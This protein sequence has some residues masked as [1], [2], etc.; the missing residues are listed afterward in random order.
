MNTE[1]TDIL[2]RKGILYRKS[3][4]PHELLLYCTSGEHEDKNPSLSFNTQKNVF[5]CWACGYKGGINKFLTSIGEFTPI[6]S[7]KN[8]V[9]VKTL[10][11]KEK[12]ENLLNKAN[13]LTLP[14]DREPYTHPYR[15]LG[16]EVMEQQQCFTTK[17]Y[18][19]DHYLCFPIFEFGKLKF[20]EARL[21][22]HVD[23]KPKWYRFPKSVDLSTML[24]PLDKFKSNGTAILVEGLL[25]CLYLRSLGY[26]NVL[27]IFGTSGFSFAKG[28]ILKNYGVANVIPL[29]DGDLPGQRAAETIK[30]LCQRLKLNT[31]KVVLD[32][33]RDPKDYRLDELT[34]LIGEPLNK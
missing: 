21:L 19:L 4:N 34:Q 33:N 31:Q 13:Q 25:D 12:L 20:I 15:M 2:D 3:N 27:C 30:V 23:G 14:D 9:S 29:M 26:T 6:N 10:I 17:Q 16:S 5:H 11:L 28:E 22:N 8:D 1:L 7:A 32:L 18:G 24:Y